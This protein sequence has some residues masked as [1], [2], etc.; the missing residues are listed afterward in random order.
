[1]TSTTGEPSGT[2][3][4]ARDP[5]ATPPPTRRRAL[6]IGVSWFSPHPDHGLEGEGPDPLVFANDRV[7]ALKKALEHEDFGYECTTLTGTHERREPTAEQL[8][9]AVHSALTGSSADEVL[10][11]HVLSHGVPRTTGLYALGADSEHLPA[12]AVTAWLSAVEDFP[13]RARVLFLLDLCHAGQ[14]ARLDWQTRDMD[15]TNRAWVVAA[16]AGEELAVDG[17][18]TQAVAETLDR[19]RAKDIEFDR[20]R[21]FVDFVW[22]V[23]RVR[24]RLAELARARGGMTQRATAS[25]LDTAGP[26]L[27]FLPNPCYDPSPLNLARSEI[28]AQLGGEIGSFLDEVA[29]PA[30]FRRHAQG[31][32][33]FPELPEA[34]GTRGLFTGRG[35]ELEELANWL[36]AVDGSR[37]RMVTGSAGVGKSA[38]LGVLLC[39]AHP[40]L[41]ER[42]GPVWQ[43]LGRSLVMS[44]A[45][46]AVHARQRTLQEIVGSTA[47]QL[48][49]SL[50]DTGA[51]TGAGTD[52]ADDW[53]AQRLVDALRRLTGPPPV[54]LIDALD[55][56]RNPT[57]TVRALLQPLLS[58]V[59]PDGAAVCRLL[60][61]ARDEE[62]F[63]ALNALARAS[64]DLI[65][66]DDVRPE[67]LTGDLREYIGKLLAGTPPDPGPVGDSPDPAADPV[68]EFASATARALAGGQE[69]TGPYLMAAL[70][71]SYAL[72][73]DVRHLLTDPGTARDLGARVPLTLPGI[74][75][76]SFARDHA[77]QLLR[78]VLTALAFTQGDGMPM[79]LVA[80]VAGAFSTGP[81]GGSGHAPGAGAAKVGQLLDEVSAFL[82]AVPDRD[83][84]MLHRL[85]HQSVADELRRGAARDM[86]DRTPETVVHEALVDS[87]R[88]RPGGRPRWED[89]HGYLHRHLAQHAV[90]AGRFDELCTEPEFLVHADPDWLVPEL[91]HARS[92]AAKNAESVYRTSAHLHR[93]A[94]AEQRRHILALDAVRHEAYTLADRLTDPAPGS[95]TPMLWRPSW[96]TGS[97]ISAAHAFTLQ[98]PDDRVTALAGASAGGDPVVVTGSRNG[99]LRVWDARNGR[100]LAAADPRTGEIHALTRTEIDGEPVLLVAG[101]NG[102]LTLWGLPGLDPMGLPPTGHKETVRAIACG[103]VVGVDVAVT[104][105]ESG[106]LLM[107]DLRGVL[108]VTELTVPVRLGRITALAHTEDGDETL[109]VAADEEGTVRVWSPVT[110]EERG[111]GIRHPPRVNALACAEFRGIPHIVTAGEDGH[112][113]VWNARTLALAARS[114]APHDGPVYALACVAESDGVRVLS[115]GSDGTIRS[116]N[117][118]DTADLLPEQNRFVGHMGAVTALARP[119]ST[120]PLLVSAGTDPALRVW[121]VPRERQRTTTPVGHTSWVNALAVT[122]LGHRP[123][124]A[125]AGADG[126]I[127]RWDLADG[128]PLGTPISTGAGPVHALA[129]TT[130][131]DRPLLVSA[132]ADGHLRRWDLADG[133]PYGAPVRVGAGPVHALAATTLADRP[134]LVSG[135]ADGLVRCWD[136]THTRRRGLSLEGHRGGVN[137]VACVEVG[138]R[139]TA[140]SCGDDG[141]LRVWD[142]ETGLPGRAPVQA[143]RGW[144]TALACAVVD[145]VALAVT[146]G[147]DGTVRVWDLTTGAPL[148]GPLEASVGV[149]AVAC[150]TVRGTAVVVAADDAAVRVWDLASGRPR[151]NIGVPGTVP[152]LLLHGDQLALGCE[153]EVVVLRR[154]RDAEG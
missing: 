124:L 17:L 41:R 115:G 80:T 107:S 76:L 117:P 44:A 146:G 121:N 103:Q 134:L 22:F 1:M 55:E 133:T 32:A 71:A 139:P 86:T 102:A 25:A 148:T 142:L 108:P 97:R 40:E 143:H 2:V 43:P 15:G 36:E 95:G 52:A 16:A 4:G 72:Q 3:A 151:E 89:L 141:T 8:G 48:R 33:G 126:H 128:T 60:L 120:P 63:T 47:R 59:R 23:D 119:G 79:G 136:V 10:I 20:S 37:L 98:V 123:A 137:A 11:V 104:G 130:L 28:T 83:G 96:A 49:L 92:E 34:D 149:N 6:S 66:L 62:P 29:D 114:A 39:A 109:I 87:L 65:D 42:T 111:T 85:L 135:G 132:G 13:R 112:V 68:G 118:E 21:P 57:E 14:A 153:W 125:S 19:M 12:T 69:A 99:N 9:A 93:G 138:A 82:R 84:T 106:R 31:G 56:T 53:N 38:L 75:D 152:A 46:A 64:G 101:A 24:E 144:A 110:E 18:F 150:G 54:V 26:E 116:W 35:P 91:R 7:A 78:P 154:T 45:L 61:G 51:G 27:P 73:D 58:A 113:R 127:H 145:G 147:Q 70:Y 74:L 67:A 94:G 30:H 50:G 129:A 131:D 140:V 100:E 105:D 81:D 90:D 5:S 88:D 77:H 122:T